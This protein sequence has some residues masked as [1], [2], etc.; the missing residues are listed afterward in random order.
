MV[1]LQWTGSICGCGPSWPCSMTKTYFKDS[2]FSSDAHSNH[3]PCRNENWKQGNE[4]KSDGD[5]VSV[6][7]H[8]KYNTHWKKSTRFRLAFRIVVNNHIIILEFCMK[9]TVYNDT[10]GEGWLTAE[11]FCHVRPSLIRSF[12]LN[13]TPFYVY[14]VGHGGLMD[15]F[16]LLRKNG[17]DVRWSAMFFSEERRS[18]L[19]LSLPN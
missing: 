4:T 1:I 16:R 9:T 2:L 19:T 14:M 18:Y 10:W 13:C 17:R 3:S 12:V 7:K 11:I 5:K 8:L 15:F 6:Q